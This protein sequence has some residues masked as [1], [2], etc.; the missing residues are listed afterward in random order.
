[1]S[2]RIQ[3]TRE[4][5][6]RLSNRVASLVRDEHLTELSAR[7]VVQKF[8]LAQQLELPPE[9]HRKLA[10]ST[11][12][13]VRDADLVRADRHPL[14]ALAK[15]LGEGWE[16]IDGSHLAYGTR[17]KPLGIDVPKSITENTKQAP[18]DGSEDSDI[19]EPTLE[20]SELAGEAM[21]AGML[22]IFDRIKRIEQ[23]FKSLINAQKLLVERLDQV[24]GDL[25]NTTEF[26]TLI[27]DELDD[28]RATVT[29]LSNGIKVELPPAP[30]LAVAVQATDSI[31]VTIVG[32]RD[33]DSSVVT[34]KIRN[35]PEMKRL[36]LRFIPATRSPFDFKSDY[37]LVMRW[38]S[39][40]WFEHAKNSVRDKANC[41]FL[42]H[43][44][45]SL[46]ID[47]L[48]KIAD[49]EKSR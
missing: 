1:M 14:L 22:N 38:V 16:V 21:A 25:L 3:W 32:L 20:H 24:D 33:R 27:T 40:A 49:F 26:D 44:G 4:E 19:P 9:R 46:L 17:I 45:V 13:P 36:N 30:R 8:A 2:E 11:S 12:L 35:L 37:A 6:G 28:I 43:T 48:R 23:G 31:Q 10:S 39:H 29:K 18:D 34:A 41:I 7:G 5:V 47:E 15:A 42:S